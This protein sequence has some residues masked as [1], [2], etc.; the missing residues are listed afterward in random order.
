MTKTELQARIAET[1]AHFYAGLECL[2][3]ALTATSEPETAR[4]LRESLAAFERS[5]TPYDAVMALVRE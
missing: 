2:R 3:A 4:L 5:E 1:E